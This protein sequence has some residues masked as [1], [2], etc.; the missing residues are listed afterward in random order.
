MKPS[1]LASFVCLVLATGCGSETP[2][3]TDATVRDTT[4]PRDATD[5]S[6]TPDTADVA[7]PRDVTDSGRVT[8]DASLPPPQCSP[9]RLD[10]TSLRIATNGAGYFRAIGGSERGERVRRSA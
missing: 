6:A 8:I 7:P 9:L 3:P 5:V 10:P 2:T 4:P 1:R